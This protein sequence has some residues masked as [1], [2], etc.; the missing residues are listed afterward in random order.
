MI[1][2]ESP[3]WSLMSS[4]TEICLTVILYIRTNVSRRLIDLQLISVMWC[5]TDILQTRV[6]LKVELLW[7]ASMGKVMG[8]FLLYCIT[9]EY[10]R[11]LLYTKQ[12]SCNLNLNRCGSS[13]WAQ[14]I[15]VRVLMMMY[16][17]LTITV[18]EVQ[19][20]AIR[21][22]FLS[23]QSVSMWGIKPS[24]ISCIGYKKLLQR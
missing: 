15:T 3:S 14:R 12:T 24:P 23:L 13:V 20:T 4:N 8:C 11:S 9:E 17:L 22:V 16:L 21:G 6:V 2:S 1:L 18:S 7:L 10:Y 5:G 19:Y